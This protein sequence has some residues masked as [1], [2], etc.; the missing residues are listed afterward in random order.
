MCSIEEA[1]G[2]NNTFQEKKVFTHSDVRNQYMNT[3]ENLNYPSMSYGPMTKN[4]PAKNN[5]T[6]GVHS[7]LSR[8][9]R[10]NPKEYRNRGQNGNVS[11]KVTPDYS[12]MNQNQTDRPKHL[13]LFPKPVEMIPS[14]DTYPLPVKSEV[15]DV[16]EP[17][18]GS[19]EENFVPWNESFQVSND[20]DH[21][22]NNGL[23]N[24]QHLTDKGLYGEYGDQYREISESDEIYHQGAVPPIPE[25]NLPRHGNNTKMGNDV[26]QEEE[27]M[28]KEQQ[29]EIVVLLN[30]ILARVE[31]LEKDVKQTPTYTKSDLIIYAILSAIGGIILYAL[32]NKLMVSKK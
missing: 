19:D 8:K 6:R 28:H 22:M 14:M 29:E 20:V 11:L 31:R 9:P 16:P 4:L 3:P 27:K 25:R 32:L 21:F 24:P 15:E 23:N 5:F 12:A 2:S 26:V 1:W 17:F 13:D 10:M 30:K 18:T 7:K